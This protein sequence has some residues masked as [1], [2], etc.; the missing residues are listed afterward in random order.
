M[1]KFKQ[2][3]VPVWN[4]IPSLQ[5]RE[6]GKASLEGGGLHLYEAV[7]WDSQS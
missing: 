7:L 1:S 6:A 4:F 3:L 2:I 5:P